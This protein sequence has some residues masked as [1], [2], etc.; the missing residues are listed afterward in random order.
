MCPSLDD[1]LTPLKYFVNKTKA[2][3]EMEFRLNFLLP[4]VYYQEKLSLE[5]TLCSRGKK[6]LPKRATSIH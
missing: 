3:R 1:A 5:T 6:E 2:H 4:L